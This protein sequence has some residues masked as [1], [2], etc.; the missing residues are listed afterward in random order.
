MKKMEN[1]LKLLLSAVILL[2]VLFNVVAFAVP[3]TNHYNALFWTSYMTVIASMVAVFFFIA[4]PLNVDHYKN[5]ETINKIT[6]FSCLFILLQTGLGILF[7][8]LTVELWIGIIVLV[9]VLVVMLFLNIFVLI[10]APK[11]ETED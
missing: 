3:F 1:K 4:I 2:L 10:Q 9:T 7:M 8:A 6:L 5:N 11:E